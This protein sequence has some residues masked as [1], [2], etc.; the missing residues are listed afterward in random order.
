MNFIGN[1]KNRLVGTNAIIDLMWIHFTRTQSPYKWE[2]I[3]EMQD[4]QKHTHK[5]IQNEL[6]YSCISTFNQRSDKERERKKYREI[7]FFSVFL[8]PLLLSLVLVLVL[9][10][11]QMCLNFGKFLCNGQCV[12]ARFFLHWFRWYL[13]VI[14]HSYGHCRCRLYVSCSEL[15]CKNHMAKW[16]RK[17]EKSVFYRF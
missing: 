6:L 7:D 8:F 5:K 14:N 11:Q 15:H 13:L 2:T 17:R 10:L 4:I 3:V 1:D 12:C 9:P 16:K